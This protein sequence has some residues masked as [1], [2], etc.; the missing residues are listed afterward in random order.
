MNQG[1]AARLAASTL[2][3]GVTMVG[4]TP[5]SQTARPA[6]FS[7]SAPRADRDAAEF[8]ARAQEAMRQNKLADALAHT[9]DAVALAPRDVGYRMLLGDLYLKS[10][11]FQSAATTFDDV[12]TLDPGNARASLSIALSQIALGKTYAA[13]SH[14]DR[15]SETAAPGDVGL[16]YALAGETDRAIALLEPAARAPDADARV[17][18]NLALAYALAGD[19]L[20]AR[21]TAAQDISPAQLGDRMEQWA[22]LAKP[23]A[24]WTQVAGLLG[25]TPT[26]DPG[27]PVRLALAPEA[28]PTRFAG[29]AVEVPA[30]VEPAPAPV[31]LAE[32]APVSAPA[33]VEVAFAP[34]PEAENAVISDPVPVATPESRFADVVQ[35]LVD[36]APAVVEPSAPV[37][38]ASVP[39]FEPTRKAPRIAGRAERRRDLQAALGATPS[40]FVVQI[41]AFSTPDNVERAWA[42]AVDRFP[43]A[44]ERVPLSTTVSI[45]GRGTFYR[46]S[47]SGF[48][49]RGDANALCG[50]IRGKGGE[51]F[52]RE[53]AGDA[54][55]RWA[56]RYTRNG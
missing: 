42:M 21:T 5:S 38:K 56:S 7:S 47:V 54:P 52:V 34:P 25:V 39:A 32:A 27:Q 23:E 48:D 36:P 51:C 2:V 40:R 30:P 37:I 55:V 16:A 31:E 14:L 45:P 22:A 44:A 15:L 4:C 41:G 17:R 10:G 24:S 46:L 35:T 1:V 11:R 33:P 3:L 8:Y 28:S 12:L 13:L 9:E 49:S 43:S 26:Q 50:T 19:W 6:S 20:K 18:Q 29:V 53:T